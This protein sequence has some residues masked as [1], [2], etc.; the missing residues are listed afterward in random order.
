[1][2]TTCFTCH[3]KAG[4]IAFFHFAFEKFAITVSLKNCALLVKLF[5]K[6]NDYAPVSLHKFQKLKG[7]KKGSPMTVQGLVKMI[8]KFEMTGF[9]DMQSGRG[10]KR[11]DLTITERG[12]ERW[13]ET[14]QYRRNCP[15]IG[16]TCQHGAQNS[17]KHPALLSLQ[18]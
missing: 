14:M 11:I 12:V 13:S 15:N 5:Y 1:M 10:K 16:Q 7:M 2:H 8:K 18:N 3:K 17:T 4:Y 6:N 9:F